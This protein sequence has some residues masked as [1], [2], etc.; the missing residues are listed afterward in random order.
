MDPDA[1]ATDRRVNDL[2]HHMILVCN[3]GYSSSWAAAVLS[4]IGFTAISDISGGFRAWRAA[5]LPTVGSS[6]VPPKP[7]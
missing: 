5:E 6:G 4:D 2:S 7:V 1:E 3:D